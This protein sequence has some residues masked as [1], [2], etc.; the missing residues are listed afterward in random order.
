MYILFSVCYYVLHMQY[1]SLNENLLKNLACIPATVTTPKL[2][3]SHQFLTRRGKLPFYFGKCV[4]QTWKYHRWRIKVFEKNL[5]VFHVHLWRRLSL[6]L[7]VL[8]VCSHRLWLF[9]VVIVSLGVVTVA[10]QATVKFLGDDE[11]IFS[12]WNC[13]ILVYLFNWRN[14]ISGICF[15][16]FST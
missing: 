10:G 16:H 5:T 14:W 15:K 2:V 1:E 11:G 12:I 7:L 9:R 6:L 8:N 3:S 4:R 13:T